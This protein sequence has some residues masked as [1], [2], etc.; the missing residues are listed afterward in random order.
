MLADALEAKGYLPFR[1]SSPW[2]SAW[3]KAFYRMRLEVNER[4]RGQLS[5]LPEPPDPD[6]GSPHADARAGKDVWQTIPTARTIVPMPG[7]PAYL[8]NRVAVSPE[9]SDEFER[10]LYENARGQIDGKFRQALSHM[11]PCCP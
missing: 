7:L 11:P 5:V 4:L 9:R 8:A 1:E 2:K 3:Q 6:R 10:L